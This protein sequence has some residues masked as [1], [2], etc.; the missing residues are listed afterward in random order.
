MQAEDGGCE[1]LCGVFAEAVSWGVGL[2]VGALAEQCLA[3]D[4]VCGVVV[5][6]VCAAAA[7]VFCISLPLPARHESHAQVRRSRGR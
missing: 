1:G 4:G 5:W 6:A 2:G 3:S 7:V